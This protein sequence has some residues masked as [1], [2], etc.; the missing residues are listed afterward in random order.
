MSDLSSKL[1]IVQELNHS[2]SEYHRLV[3]DD[4]IISIL[5]YLTIIKFEYLSCSL[6]KYPF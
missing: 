6:I 4:D 5:I 1:F 2:L 3:S